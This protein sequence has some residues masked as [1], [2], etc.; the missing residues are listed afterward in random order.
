MNCM[1][2]H[3]LVSFV[4][5]MLYFLKLGPLKEFRPLFELVG[6]MAEG[7]RIGIANELDL[8]MKFQVWREQVPFTIRNDPYSLKRADSSPPIMDKLFDGNEFKFHKFMELLLHAVEDAVELIFEQKKNPPKLKC[9]TTNID[10]RHGKTP[11]NGQCKSKLV[12]NNLVQC[13]ECAVVISQTKSGIALQLEW[14]QLGKDSKNIY[15]SI[16]IIPIFQIEKIS[17][18]D[19]ARLINENMLRD[20][21]PAEWLT[22]I[23]KYSKEYKLIKEISQ[24]GSGDITSVGIK[25]MNFLEGRN[26]HI[27]PAQ[28]FTRDKF[29][30]PRMKTIYGYIKFLKKAR[31]LDMSSYWIKKELLKE[32]YQ[33]ILDLC[34]EGTSVADK[35]D[36][37]LVQI[38]SQPAFKLKVMR[39][40]NLNRSL[41]DGFIHVR[42]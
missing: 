21:S 22:F 11:C 31:N 23:F 28:K 14:E 6:S 39:K 30:S 29:S 35:D 32:E 15:C 41:E 4:Q 18:M 8:G 16:D 7:T 19:L 24:D 40:I 36:L 26:H 9:I 27:K 10:W 34:T 20:D 37:A 25:T 2:A 17:A 33:S 5:T 3:D 38:L 1:L 12:S 42:R 13:K